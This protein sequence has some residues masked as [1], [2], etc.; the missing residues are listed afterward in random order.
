MD[1][2]QSEAVSDI[3]ATLFCALS[4]VTCEFARSTF[5][6]LHGAKLRG[7]VRKF[8]DA[9]HFVACCQF[10]DDLEQASGE[11]NQPL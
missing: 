5:K 8:V 4:D 9:L 6:A 7:A 1:Y 10:S 11:T 3:M 2:C